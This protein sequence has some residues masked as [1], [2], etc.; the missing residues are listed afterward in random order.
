MNFSFDFGS[1]ISKEK[2]IMEV[3]GTKNVKDDKNF[4]F[5]QFIGCLF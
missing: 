4:Q 3:L 2:R 5:F 1:R